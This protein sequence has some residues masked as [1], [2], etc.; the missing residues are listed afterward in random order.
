MSDTI[1]Q[2][3]TIVNKIY[4]IRGQKVML[5][6]DLAELYGVETKR[7]NEAIKRNSTRFPEDFMFQL[8]DNEEISLRSQFATLKKYNSGRGQHRKYKPYVFTEHGTV[9]LASVLNSP[10]AVNASILVVRTF[11][12]LRQFLSENQALA[13][14]IADLER[15]TKAELKEHSEQIQMIFEAIQQLVDEKEIP[16]EPIGFKTPKEI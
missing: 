10:A 2:Q 9:M 1:L 3:E 5:D 12:K 11:V 8:T 14:K 7:L 13:Q 16:R 15:E 4:H 6:E